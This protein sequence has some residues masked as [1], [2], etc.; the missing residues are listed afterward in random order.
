MSSTAR[1]ASRENLDFYP[2]PGWCV[3]LLLGA[4]YAPERWIF[5]AML[6]ISDLLFLEC[7]A[8]DGAV[9]KRLLARGAR[10]EN[11]DAI[12][13]DDERAA[14][15]A[16]STGVDVIVVDTAHGH[17]QGV[18]DRVR[19][20]KKNFP[21]MQVI[22][23][24]TAQQ[25]SDADAERVRLEVVDPPVVPSVPSGP[26]RLPPVPSTAP[27]NSDQCSAGRNH[28][29]WSRVHSPAMAKAKG[30]TVLAKPRNSV[31]G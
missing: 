21:Q 3:D 12:E 24:E 27:E 8:G 13:L 26:N 22:G 28:S 19:W 2:T 20:V 4:L 17:S 14:L 16:R 18:L 15:C 5:P 11:I 7:A 25:P 9:I 23:G 29:L 6:P 10:S 30:T 31:G 1:G